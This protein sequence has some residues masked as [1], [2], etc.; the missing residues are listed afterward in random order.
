MINLW[1]KI[2]NNERFYNFSN[3]TIYKVIYLFCNSTTCWRKDPV[4]TDVQRKHENPNVGLWMPNVRTGSQIN[5]HITF[6]RKTPACMFVS[7]HKML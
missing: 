2:K 7:L 6:Y 5:L 3:S 4:E 1:H